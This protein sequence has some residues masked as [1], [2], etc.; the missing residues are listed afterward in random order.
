MNKN[1]L[2]IYISIVFFSILWCIAPLLN[3]NSFNLVK[4]ATTIYL[5]TSTSYLFIVKNSKYDLSYITKTILFIF[6]Y[7]TLETM[8]TNIEKYPF[9]MWQQLF[10]STTYLLLIFYYLAVKNSFKDKLKVYFIA[11]FHVS[12]IFEVFI[13][14]YMIF[15]SL[16]N[17]LTILFNNI[18]IYNQIQIILIPSLI[19]MLSFVKNIRL[20]LLLYNA[21]IFNFL[22]LLFTGARGVTF[23]LVIVF[24][25]F[26]IKNRGKHSKKIALQ[27]FISS[28]ISITIYTL[29]TYT[30][31]L[32]NSNLK[33]FDM[34]LNPDGRLFIY[35]TELKMLL[36]ANYLFKSIGFS[37]H[38]L[39]YFG[40][41]HPHDLLLYIANGGGIFL[42]IFASIALFTIIVTAYKYFSFKTIILF[43]FILYSMFSGTY[44]NPL[45]QF[46]FTIFLAIFYSTHKHVY[47]I[48]RSTIMIMTSLLITT[49]L[50]NIVAL[51]NNVR[52]ALIHTKIQ[53]RRYLKYG[54]GIFIMNVKL[55]K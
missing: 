47:T 26:I 19:I 53:K 28:C 17:S 8:N 34:L 21:I 32:N 27:I 31:F 6:L 36:N 23:T 5:L 2:H 50:L 22:I 4:I 49:I 42:F 25:A 29:L 18:R 41:F 45:A 11:I 12:I 52:Y 10:I 9:S 7:T 15:S 55:L 43:A 1:Y 24:I 38:K 20:K 39:F 30:S 51:D 37:P 46:Y 14:L 44:I 3:I 33:H 54:E 35:K 48:S 16:N 13:I 40:H